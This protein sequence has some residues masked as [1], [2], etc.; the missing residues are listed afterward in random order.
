MSEVTTPTPSPNTL[1]PE[2]V[3]VLGLATQ[4]LTAYHNFGEAMDGRDYP[5]GSNMPVMGEWQ[6]ARREQYHA[7]RNALIEELPA[8]ARTLAAHAQAPQMSGRQVL[9]DVE[10][11]ERVLPAKWPGAEV[12]RICCVRLSPG[13]KHLSSCPIPAIQAALARLSHSPGQGGEQ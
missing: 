6:Y 8:I 10:V 7:A 5:A 9:V 2:Q 4:F 12:C 11:L 13:E 1:T 3:R